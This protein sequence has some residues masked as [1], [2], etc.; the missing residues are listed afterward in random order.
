MIN[1]SERVVEKMNTHILCSITFFLFENRALYE[2]RWKNI[3]EPGR[4]QM[5]IWC[6]HIAC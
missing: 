3:A 6:M 5:T 2:I 1:V 4:P